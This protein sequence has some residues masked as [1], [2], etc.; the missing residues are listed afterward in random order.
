MFTDPMEEMIFEMLLHLSI[1][2]LH[3]ALQPDLV[4]GPLQPHGKRGNC[5]M[6]ALHHFVKILHKDVEWCHSVKNNH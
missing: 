1:G 2:Y 5:L 3:G 6:V 4:K